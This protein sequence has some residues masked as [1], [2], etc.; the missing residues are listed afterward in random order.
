MKITRMNLA[1]S[2]QKKSEDASRVLIYCELL[3]V[4]KRECHPLQHQ[5]L[6][7]I[8]MGNIEFMDI[9]KIVSHLQRSCSWSEPAVGPA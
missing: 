2:G 4:F 3:H 9:S 5:K 1:H 8:V 6:S 7:Q